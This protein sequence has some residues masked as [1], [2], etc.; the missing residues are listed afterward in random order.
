MA[1]D[2]RSLDDYVDVAERMREFY[3]KYPEGSLRAAVP[4]KPWEL[5][6]VSGTKK[7]GK[8]TTQTFIVYTA[9][10]Y[11]HP[12][13]P[14]PGVG[15]AWEIWPGRTPY[16]LGSELMNAETSAWGRAMA[17]LGIATKR[18]IASRQEVQNRRAEREDG[19]PVNADGSLSRSQTT[20]EEK[21][22]AGVMTSEQQAEHTALRKGT[23]TED[24]LPKASPKQETILATPPDDPFYNIPPPE[25]EHRPKSADEDQV[26]EINIRLV[27]LG[28]KDRDAKLAWLGDK[29][30]RQLASS[31]DLSMTEAAKLLRSRITLPAVKAKAVAP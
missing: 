22:K 5:A 21:D 14:A 6:I 28:I 23:G 25:P 31:K 30:G 29:V 17:A 9:V 7:D 11:R 27:A 12:G 3:A 8:E 15:V 24:K 10:A 2:Q 20:D 18:G 16:T 1:F 26:R 4:E 19:L 13:D